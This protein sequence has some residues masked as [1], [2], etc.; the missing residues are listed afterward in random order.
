MKVRL[1]HRHFGVHT[2]R[3]ETEI[4]GSLADYATPKPGDGGPYDGREYAIDEEK[5][6]GALPE[7]FLPVPPRLVLV[8]ID[9][10][11]QT[12]LKLF[13]DWAKYFDACML[14]LLSP[15]AEAEEA[16]QDEQGETAS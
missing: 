2:V 10:T 12:G 9:D 3:E 8:G 5:L 4:P 1:T 15:Q 13:H 11:A 16:A 14:W 6:L 7:G